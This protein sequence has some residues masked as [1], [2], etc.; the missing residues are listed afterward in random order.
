MTNESL[1]RVFGLKNGYIRVE[2]CDGAANW[3]V[4]FYRMPNFTM[5]WA[6]IPVDSQPIFLYN[7]ITNRHRLHH[8]TMSGGL[9]PYR[10]AAGGTWFTWEV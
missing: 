6:W 7:D 5:T 10:R 2:N 1:A 9:P 8:R 3:D 4:K